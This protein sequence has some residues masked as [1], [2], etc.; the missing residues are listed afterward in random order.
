MSLPLGH[1]LDLKQ[2]S[3]PGGTRG[4]RLRLE[5]NILPGGFCSWRNFNFG[6]LQAGRRKL[7]RWGFRLSTH[8][9]RPTR[10]RRFPLRASSSRSTSPPRLKV[11]LIPVAQNRV[12]VITISKKASKAEGTDQVDQQQKQQRRQALPRA[13]SVGKIPANPKRLRDSAGPV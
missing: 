5:R 2:N 12:P 11:P 6:W 1:Q 9:I 13:N 3:D 4:R 10:R 7:V 8:Q